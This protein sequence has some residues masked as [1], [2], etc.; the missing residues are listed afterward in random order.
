MTWRLAGVLRYVSTIVL[1]RYSP[2][3][4]RIP[5]TIVNRDVS[6]TWASAPLCSVGLCRSPP[7]MTRPLIP[8]RTSSGAAARIS[9]GPRTVRSFRISVLIRMFIRRLLSDVCGDRGNGG[10]LRIISGQAQEG[11]LESGSALAERGERDALLGGQPADLAGRCSLHLEAGLASDPHLEAAR[12]QQRGQVCGS[13]AAHGDTGAAEP[14]QR[15]GEAQ[16]AV[17]DDDDAVH[18]LA[19]LAEHVTGDQDCAALAGQL[20]QQ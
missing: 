13:R 6:P 19:D 17:A 11:R 16:R 14:G 10:R 8:A 7:E 12:R 2:A 4:A 9:Q 18:G 5:N 3:T 15:P 1:C 20:A